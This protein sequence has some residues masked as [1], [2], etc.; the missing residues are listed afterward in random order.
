MLVCEYSPKTVGSL[1][2]EERT[3]NDPS[4][5]LEQ[6]VTSTYYTVGK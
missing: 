2:A 6:D 1:W 4:S 3:V 5:L